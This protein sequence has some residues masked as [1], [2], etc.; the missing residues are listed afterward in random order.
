[1]RCLSI[2]WSVGTM[3]TELDHVLVLTVMH[4]VSSSAS[5]RFQEHACILVAREDFCLLNLLRIVICCYSVSCTARRDGLADMPRFKRSVGLSLGV[6]S[7]MLDLALEEALQAVVGVGPGVC[8]MM[9]PRSKVLAAD[10]L[11]FWS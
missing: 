3:V 11:V 2:L 4:V 1:M 9:L 8:V 7:Q 6:F 10:P 5:S